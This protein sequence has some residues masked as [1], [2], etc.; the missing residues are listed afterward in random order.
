MSEKC[1][2]LSEKCP[3]I[4]Q[5]GGK[6]K[7]GHILDIFC[8]FGRR[9]CLVTCPMHARYKDNT[10]HTHV[11]TN[12]SMVW[13]IL[14]PAVHAARRMRSLRVCS[15]DSCIDDKR[16]I[17]RSLSETKESCQNGGGKIHI[18]HSRSTAFLSFLFCPITVGIFHASSCSGHKGSNAPSGLSSCIKLI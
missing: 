17:A 2:K 7:F 12:A 4:V 14:G 11:Q 8:L 10:N 3:K 18:S 16:Y 15:N 9:F 6:H 5:R 13:A 1:R